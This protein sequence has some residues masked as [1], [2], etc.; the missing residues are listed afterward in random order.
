MSTNAVQC[1][2]C[3]R[4]EAFFYR[5]Y[6]GEKLCKKCFTES[7]EAKVKAT[8]AKYG[9][10]QFDDRIVIAVSGG[11]D[12]VSLLHILAKIERDYPKASLMAVTVD[13]GI[14]GY[15]DEALKIARENCKKLGIPHHM[16]SFKELY[17]YR[18][19]EIVKK[20]KEKRD[21]KLTPC[22][23]CSV[24]R[25]KALNITARK[26]EANKIATAHTLDD[27]TQTILLN[28]FHGD[29]LRIARGK[30]VADET[31]PKLVQKVKPFCEIP[32]KET[33]LYAY[34]K[35]IKFQSMPCPYASEALRND[36]RI[37]LNRMEEKH[38]GIKFTIFNSI[39][40]VRPA[41][42]KLAR[43]EGLKE[44]SECGEPTTDRICKA[45]QML[46][47]IG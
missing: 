34:V 2:I 4:R 43:R 11:K 30:P 37:M 33:A 45:C 8:I 13:E 32:E 46:K 40:K 3:K 20:V 29:I 47:E 17:G 18:L 24:M 31:H 26:L 42:E 36:I 9:M 25:R 16:V 14:R 27:E 35:K 15:R 5:Q 6:S 41:L 21:L 19:D 7:I 12:S 23:Y 44:C 22:A 28:I 1:S 38:A 39:E 10:L